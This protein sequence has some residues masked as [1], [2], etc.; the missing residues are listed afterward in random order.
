MNTGNLQMWLKALQ[1]TMNFELVSEVVFKRLIYG[2]GPGLLVIYGPPH[3]PPYPEEEPSNKTF[4]LNVVEALQHGCP[5][6]VEEWVSSELW[7]LLSRLR[8]D[9]YQCVNIVKIIKEFNLEHPGVTSYRIPLGVTT[10]VALS[11][12]AH[13]NG[14]DIGK[15]VV[16]LCDDLPKFMNYNTEANERFLIELSRVLDNRP[17]ITFLAAARLKGEYS[18]WDAPA[19]LGF[20]HV[21]NLGWD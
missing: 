1:G 9:T 21:L 13:T 3:D 20:E 4:L 10:S 14:I 8:E 11:L 6:I 18:G 19:L 2:Q 17:E 5:E 12:V 15:K 7:S 16:I